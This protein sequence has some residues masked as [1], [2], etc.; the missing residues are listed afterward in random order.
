MGYGK[1]DGQNR[2]TSNS[3]SGKS[4]MEITSKYDDQET[5][6]PR[7]LL[8]EFEPLVVQKHQYNATGIEDQIISLYTK[9]VSTG[10][11]QDHLQNLY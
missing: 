10:K 9:G 3:R 11:I 8:G 7:D 2:Q 1:H 5:F 4:K 6:V